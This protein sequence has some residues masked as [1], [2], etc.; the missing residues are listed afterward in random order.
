MNKEWK[1]YIFTMT[2]E[3]EKMEPELWV[4]DETPKYNIEW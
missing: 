1:I 4:L 3:Q 2:V